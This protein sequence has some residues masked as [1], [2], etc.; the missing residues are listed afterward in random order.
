MKPINEDIK[1]LEISIE[2]K[3]TPIENMIYIRGR[4]DQISSEKE[5]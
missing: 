3:L 4:L 5:K 1:K 2:R